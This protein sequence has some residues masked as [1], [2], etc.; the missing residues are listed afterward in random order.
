MRLI[1]PAT[2]RA[3][4]SGARNRAVAS[5][6]GAGAAAGRQ[7]LRPA[8]RHGRRR[9]AACPILGGML[10]A[11]IPSVGCGG[12]T[13]KEP[14]VLG[15]VAPLHG[16]EAFLGEH[17]R[18]GILLATE[19]ADADASLVAG[20]R[21][22]VRHA[23]GT[24]KDAG[25]AAVRLITVNHVVA[26]IGGADPA[27]GEALAGI[28]QS[29]GVPLAVPGGVPGRTRNP[30]V[31]ALGLAPSAKGEALAAFTMHDLKAERAL[32]LVNDEES[33][34]LAA[35]A[36][37]A[38]VAAAFAREHA[39]KGG[40]LAVQWNYKGPAGLRSLVGRAR[41]LKPEAVLVAGT[42]ED[43]AELAAGG[44]GEK[45]AVL[46][47]GPEESARQ[48]A[49]DVPAVPLYLATAFSADR[50]PDEAREFARKYEL[51]FGEAPDAAAALAY[52]GTRFLTEGIRSTLSG[53]GISLR[54]ALAAVKSFASL[55]GPITLEDGKAVRPAFIVRV[56]G[57]SGKCVGR[58]PSAK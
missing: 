26:L 34:G 45:T 5:E 56:E 25:P 24:G 32:V 38:E 8:S 15:H 40:K 23:D 4:P 33:H 37:A 16:A 21:L 49:V 41:N 22:L 1:V 51:R 20:R 10:A 31:F 46:F 7:A 9:G 30:L 39:R 42:P 43:L 29:Y 50:L 17:A 18:Q 36:Y 58:Y 57:G 53:D 35:T 28:A 48:L 52:D 3:R 44:L 27:Q 19:E 54:D 13:E 11:V 12:K 55:T 47:G 14:V 2:D 6:S